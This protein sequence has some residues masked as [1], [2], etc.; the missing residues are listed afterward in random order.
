MKSNPPAPG[1]AIA[2]F[3]GPGGTYNGERGHAA[4]FKELAGECL[5]DS[6][7]LLP[8]RSLSPCLPVWLGYDGHHL[9]GW[10]CHGPALSVVLAGNGIVVYDQWVGHPVSIRTLKY[11]SGSTDYSNDGDLFYTIQTIRCTC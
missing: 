7:A 8:A 9:L 6:P 4:I 10:L 1:T 3:S 5:F 2:S 11:K